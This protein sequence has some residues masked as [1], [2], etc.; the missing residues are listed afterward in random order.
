MSARDHLTPYP[1]HTEKGDD[2]RTVL[3]KRER[4]REAYRQQVQAR[5]V[6]FPKPT[7]F[8]AA[9]IVIGIAVIVALRLL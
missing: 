4:S 8:D 2:W 7:W 1:F 3:A 6:T 9:L 5:V